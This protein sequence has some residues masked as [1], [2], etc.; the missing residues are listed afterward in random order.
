MS[1]TAKTVLAAAM[2]A[3]ATLGGTATSA[4]GQWC[5]V[6]SCPECLNTNAVGDSGADERPRISTNGQGTWIAVWESRVNAGG[7][8]GTDQDILFSRSTDNG[9]T[10]TFPE[11]LDPNAL[12]DDGN[13]RSAQL[14]ADSQ[15]TWVAVWE[16]EATL[17]GAIG[18]DADILFSRSTDNG[19]TWTPA[20]ALNT[21]AVSDVGYDAYP[22]VVSG[23]QGRWLAVWNS[24][25]DLDGTIGTD[26]DI[27]FSRSVDGA[28]SWSAPAPLNGD[29]FGE[30]HNDERPRL[31]SDDQ[32]CWVA[33]WHRRGS[34]GAPIGGDYDIFVSRSADEGVSWSTPE[35]LNAATTDTGS[36]TVPEIATDGMGNWVVVWQ[37]NDDF[38]G[39]AG[40]DQDV[41]FS[42]SADN[43]ETWAA[44]ALITVDVSPNNGDDVRPSINVGGNG[45][46]VVVWDSCGFDDSTGSDRDVFAALSTDNGSTWTSGVPLNGNAALDDEPEESPDIAADGQGHWVGVWESNNAN[47]GP[48]KDILVTRVVLVCEDCNGNSVM[49]GCDIADGTSQDCNFDYVPD[50]CQ[51]DEDC[52]ANTV[53][54]IC[55]IGE[56][57]SLDCNANLVPDECDIAVG[58]SPDCDGGGVPDECE[59]GYGS[60]EWVGPDEG[61]F[62]DPANWDPAGVPGVGG[63]AVLSNDTEVDNRNVL[64]GSGS[65]EICTLSIGAT[66]TGQQ[67]LRIEDPAELIVHNATTISAGGE[68][69]LQ[70]GVLESGTVTDAGSVSGAGEVSADFVNQ[71]EITGAAGG[72]LLFS[73]S[74]FENHAS[75]LIRAPFG[76]LVYV[77][78][79]GVTQGGQLEIDT[80]AG[81]LFDAALTNLAGGTVT[82]LGGSLGA[83]S[84]TNDASGLVYGFGTVDADAT[85]DGEMTFV[86][87][88]EIV[89]DLANNGLVTIQSGLLTILG[90]L[91]GSGTIVGD[92]FGRSGN[93]GLTVL[94]DYQAAAMGSLQVANGTLKLAGD[95][96]VAINDP[97]RFDLTTGTLQLVGLPE[98]DPQLIEVLAEDVG[99][100]V[101]LPDPALFSFGGIRIGPV[102]TT[103]QLVDDH[104]NA[105]GAGAEAVYVEQLILEEDTTM[106]LA[107]H[108]VYYVTMTPEDP[109]APGSGV[110]VIDSVGGGALIPVMTV[111][112]PAAEEGAT[113]KNRYLSFQPNNAD[114]P[115]AFHVELTASDYFPG[116]VGV[117]GW[118]GEPD[119]DDVCRLVPEAYY[120]DAWPAIVHVGDCHVV[121]AATYEV[122]ATCNGEVF[123]GPLTVSTISPPGT[124]YWADVVG[125]FA[126]TWEPPN[127][128]VNMSDIQAILQAF[129]GLETAPHLTWVDLD[130]AVPNKI[131]NMTDVQQA[132]AGFKGEP[133]P[134]SDPAGCP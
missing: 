42:R 31:A 43:G 69:R 5:P 59:A 37:S 95:F 13:D 70:D 30:S 15:G 81:M 78:S 96:D 20:A 132:V 41:I 46:W 32:G 75:G 68:I 9:V 120:N 53:R 85:N 101:V 33:V 22:H 1:N 107:G 84:L 91:T 50:E 4:R 77:A 47:F 40:G 49:D 60:F 94:G 72:M 56:G 102:A 16:S 106:D 51:P 25:D 61:M 18:D 7:T 26:M 19:T 55:D 86:A 114:T 6:I 44:P 36:D 109:Y 83:P 111:E 54:D 45:R 2:L 97:A 121:P 116:S 29:A 74:I 63:D 23:G 80:Q 67:I 10:W 24:S 100:C 64:S 14:S 124:K 129:S 34:A 17:G 48:D 92:F 62:E 27:L 110:T 87:D 82:I 8:V 113:P 98:D 99:A 122:T 89:G 108:H 105:S 71:G 133:Y 73:G 12:A 93:D 38:G 52:N 115:V 104:D 112:P 131:V 11:G 35:P 88:T 58:T 125:G 117:D 118:V 39:V 3:A 79:T 126:G 76:S 28:T 21:N 123:T 119:V 127:G 90:S 128:V 66:S 103:V 134:F 57:T 65:R 130:G